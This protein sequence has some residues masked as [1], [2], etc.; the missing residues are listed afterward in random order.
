MFS[1]TLVVDVIEKTYASHLPL[2]QQAQQIKRDCGE[3]PNPSMLSDYVP[4]AAPSLR[5]VNEGI[6]ADLLLGGY[7]RTNK[8]RGAFAGSRETG[9]APHRLLLW[10]FTTPSSQLVTWLEFVRMHGEIFE[11]GGRRR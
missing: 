11:K 10:I 9:I 6:N 1:H 8:T 7:I 4:Q 3:E 5:I 2:Y